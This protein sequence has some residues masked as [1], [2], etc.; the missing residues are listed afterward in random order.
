MTVYI[1]VVRGSKQDLANRSR[2]HCFFAFYYLVEVDIVNAVIDI[3]ESGTVK[4]YE[5]IWGNALTAALNGR[6]LVNFSFIL[7]IA[8]VIGLNVSIAVMEIATWGI[9]ALGTAE[10]FLLMRKEHAHRGRMVQWKVGPDLALWTYAFFVALGVLLMPRTVLS[11][12][13]ILGFLRWIIVIYVFRALLIRF[14]SLQVMYVMKAFT[15]GVI[16]AG[17]YGI[18]QFFTGME[19]F[20]SGRV[21]LHP[22]GDVWRATGFFSQS[23]TYSYSIGMGG[24]LIAGWLLH[25]KEGNG[26][27]LNKI[28]FIGFTAGGLGVL[29]SLSRGAWVGFI[30]ALPVF[31]ASLPKRLRLPCFCFAILLIVI[32]LSTNTTLLERISSVFDSNL[33][34]NR[35][36]IALSVL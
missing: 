20:R 19:F 1:Y 13:Q 25:K 30:A 21:V 7:F 10:F 2:L 34:S 15:V 27:V 23:L 18:F 24:L 36:R 31:W 12:L 8:Y 11:N 9:I 17:F 3:R 5:S 16:V 33:S 32:T 29:A 14:T 4:A 26:L 35:Q 6:S 28:S 22:Y